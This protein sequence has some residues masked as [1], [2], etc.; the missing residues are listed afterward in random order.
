MVN[1]STLEYECLFKTLKDPNNVDNFEEALSD[2]HAGRLDLDANLQLEY[3][4]FYEHQLSMC[5]LMP[6]MATWLQLMLMHRYKMVILPIIHTMGYRH[7]VYLDVENKFGRGNNTLISLG[8]Q[9]K[10][11]CQI[12]GTSLLGYLEGYCERVKNDF[13]VCFRDRIEGFPKDP[14]VWG[15]SVTVTNG[16]KV[17]AVAKYIHFFSMFGSETREP[18][19]YFTY[20]I[21]IT[22]EEEEKEGSEFH[23]CEL[24]V[25]LSLICNVF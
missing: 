13:Y 1:E 17:E 6:P 9:D 2:Y 25:R 15:G 4:E 22:S 14:R 8:G 23:S 5:L 20:Q 3:T 19:Y 18:Q 11:Y 12:I 10:K 21:R 24:T 16:V 7:C